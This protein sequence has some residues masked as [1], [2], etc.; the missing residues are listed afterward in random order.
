MTD[1]TS[2]MRALDNLSREAERDRAAR[3]EMLLDLRRRVGDDPH[4]HAHLVMLDTGRVTYGEFISG[5]VMTL[6]DEKA[7]CWKMLVDSASIA[8][9]MFIVSADGSRQRVD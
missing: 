1:S 4:I 8:S 5:L 6:A 3:V 2:M 7:R 9:P